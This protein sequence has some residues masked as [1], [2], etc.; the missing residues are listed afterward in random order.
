[1]ELR[2]W[3]VRSAVIREAAGGANSSAKWRRLRRLAPCRIR[4]EDH[5]GIG[6]LQAGT[7]SGSV[8]KRGGLT[9]CGVSRIGAVECQERIRKVVQ[10]GGEVGAVLVRSSGGQLRAECD[11]FFGDGKG[12]DARTDRGSAASSPCRRITASVYHGTDH[13]PLAKPGNCLTP[14]YTLTTACENDRGRASS[15]S[16]TLKFLTTGRNEEMVLRS[17]ASEMLALMRRAAEKYFPGSVS[18]DPFFTE[19]PIPEFAG[20]CVHVSDSMALVELGAAGVPDWLWFVQVSSGLATDVPYTR[21]LMNWVSEHNRTETIGKYYCI[22]SGI[23]PDLGSVVYETLIPGVL[24]KVLADKD[25]NDDT[26]SLAYD[27]ACWEM[28]RIIDLGADQRTEVVSKFGG[29]FFDCS[30]TGLR[31]LFAVTAGDPLPD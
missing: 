14:I 22:A 27:R 20:F 19:T 6:H 25:V 5:H 18:D 23:N 8:A 11:G 7:F 10:R 16:A 24:F 29:R 30:A 4:A 15:G 26:R 31:R 3:A 28:R 17:P 2:I 21:A 12:V 1:M 13:A 9:A